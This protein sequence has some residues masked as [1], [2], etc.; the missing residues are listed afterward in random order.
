MKLRHTIQVIKKNGQRETRAQVFDKFP[1][2]IGRGGSSNILFESKLI[3]LEHAEIDL[4]DNNPWI[5][6][7]DSQSGVYLNNEK[8]SKAA[9]KT[10]DQVKIGDVLLSITIA[11]GLIDL[12]EERDEDKKFDPEKTALTLSA[13]LSLNEHL[14]SISKI[15]IIFVGILLIFCFLPI[16][17]F[18]RNSWSPGRMT[19]NHK[20]IENKCESCHNGAFQSINDQQC[21]NCHNMSEH[22]EVLPQLIAQGARPQVKCVDCHIEHQGDHFLIEKE[23]SLCVD[24]H[25]NIQGFDSQS[26][27]LNVSTFDSHPQF[28]ISLAKEGSHFVKVGLDSKEELKDPT[29]IKLNHKVHLQ[30]GLRGPNGNVDLQCND[31]HKLSADRKNIEPITFE[32]N[33]KNCHPLSFDERLPFNEVPHGDPDVVYNY[34]FAE[35]AKFALGGVSASPQIEEEFSIRKKPG[36]TV[37]RD[38]AKAVD[39]ARDSIVQEARKSEEQLFEK[40]ACHLCH[41]EKK[42]DDLS[43]ARSNYE[44]LKPAIPNTWMKAARFSHAAHEEVQCEDCHGSRGQLVRDSVSSEDLLLPGVETCQNCHS[45]EFKLSHIKSDCVMCHS[46]HDSKEFD[47]HKKRTIKDIVV[48]LNIGE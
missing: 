47:F 39:F 32:Q 13:K 18:N 35:Y 33:C 34:L 46:Y 10:K 45:G 12:L 19:S 43:E 22:A 21:L 31:C 36:F 6:D 3:S 17:G 27:L 44:I 15:S 14:P 5:F 2:K 7:L 20:M 24:C 23:S 1:I 30:P 37:E 28:K 40:T 9:L 4:R 11:Q 16:F 8:I 25:G 48:S 29:P 26:K 38:T 42:L 41:F